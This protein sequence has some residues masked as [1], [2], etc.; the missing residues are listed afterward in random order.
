MWKV[1]EEKESWHES[2]SG[3][4]VPAIVLRIWEAGDEAAPGSGPTRYLKYTPLEETFGR[5]WEIVYD[6]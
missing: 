3:D 5:K 4:P 2:E 1:I 6:K